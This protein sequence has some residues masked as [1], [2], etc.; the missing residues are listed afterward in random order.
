M[1]RFGFGPKSTGETTRLLESG[2]PSI[3]AVLDS[4]D[5]N[6]EI[7]NKNPQLLAFLV[8]PAALEDLVT[9]LTTNRTRNAHKKF[10]QLF[11]GSATEIFSP[12]ARNLTFV[13][14]VVDQLDHFNEEFVAYG[15]GTLSRMFTRAMDKWPLGVGELIRLSELE[16]PGVLTTLVK[17]LDKGVVFQGMIDLISETHPEVTLLVWYVFRALAGPTYTVEPN[18]IPRKVFLAP[19]P[20]FGDFK[21]TT[22]Y[23]LRAYEILAA[24]FQISFPHVADFKAVVA[25]WLAT[26]PVEGFC[27]GMF[28]IAR[29]VPPNEGLKD[30]FLR[31]VREAEELR[32]EVA[33]GS[34]EYLSGCAKLL[35]W[36][37]AAGVIA[38]VLLAPVVR[39]TPGLGSLEIVRSFSDA[40]NDVDSFVAAIRQIVSAAWNRFVVSNAGQG[41]YL[42]AAICVGAVHVL[43]SKGLRVDD[44]FDKD[45]LTGWGRT[46]ER[47]DKIFSEVSVW[48]SPRPDIANPEFLEKLTRIEEVSEVPPGGTE[49]SEVPP[50]PPV[51]PEP[52]EGEAVV[53]S[54]ADSSTGTTGASGEGAGSEVP[55]GPVESNPSEGEDAVRCAP[56]AGLEGTD[57]VKEEARAETLAQPEPIPSP[58]ASETDAILASPGE[59]EVRDSTT[60]S[61]I[62][63]VEGSDAPSGTSG[64]E[65][66]G[67]EDL[68]EAGPPGPT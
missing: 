47:P 10:V 44:L 37:E 12:V 16:P 42:R 1:S 68:G 45:F 54:D 29:L 48:E 61:E 46:E 11:Q 18:K 65:L 49:V 8:S 41:E 51:E 17:H 2:H 53:P 63:Q 32:G 52:S 40:G 4:S 55:S 60:P 35:R 20:N 66:E 59:S 36:W 3:S 34:V 9:L 23:R 31:Y 14:H 5:F 57:G 62:A 33:N 38:K 28:E 50:S 64:P 25:D 22:G 21:I 27:A 24:F 26:V 6:I 19:Q 30:K 67:R 13:R 58:L 15:V 7:R 39:Q 43:W 56:A